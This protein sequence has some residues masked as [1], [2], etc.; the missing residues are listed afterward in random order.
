MRNRR[1][2]AAAVSVFLLTATAG[3][4]ADGPAAATFSLFDALGVAYQ[5][6]PQLAAAQAGVRATDETVAIANANWRPNI[7]ATGTYGFEKYKISGVPQWIGTH[8][9]NAQLGVSENIFRG[10]RTY[11]EVSQ[12]MAQVGAARAQL[13]A[14]EQTVLL[15]A[16]SAYMDVVRDTAIVELRRHNVE[17]LRKQRDSTALEFKAG[18]LTRT[19][20]A[21]SEARLAGAQAALTTAEG[22]LAISRSGFLQAVGRPAETLEPRP[23]I[24]AALPNDEGAALGFALKANPAL[25]AA[26]QNER[27]A[28]YAVDDAIGSLLPQVSVQGGYAY[29]QQSYNST[30]GA[31]QVTHGLGVIGQVTIPIY[32]G[33]AEEATVRQAKELHS[34]AALNVTVVDRQVRDAVSSAWN[35]YQAAL[36][37]ITSNEATEKADEIA[38]TGVSKEQQVGSRTILDVLNAQQELLN[39]QVAVVTSHRDAT[40]AAFQVLAAGGLLTAKT[41][42]L[43][44]NL[45]DPVAHYDSDAARWFGF[46]D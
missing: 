4:A 43:K 24:P 44:V 46:G 18:S 38:F 22:Q 19:D 25:V 20:V 10:G 37:S 31:G 21:Q 7:S 33:G 9:L 13:V 28:S 3:I 34:Q 6:N 39:A 40:L 45:Y 23:P 27:A 11:A 17:V 1:S 8:P 30:L 26:R 5:T 2:L 29:S 14:A 15:A 16:A 42:G 41:L 36:A 12:A 35:A 32:Q